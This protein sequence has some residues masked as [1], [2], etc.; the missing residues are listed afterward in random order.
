MRAACCRSTRPARLCLRPLTAFQSIIRSGGYLRADAR[1][2]PLSQLQHIIIYSSPPAALPRTAPSRC[3]LALLGAA[4]AA[5]RLLT[6]RP[7]PLFSSVPA[8]RTAPPR[9][10]CSLVLLAPPRGV[11]A[12]LALRALL[13]SVQAP[14]MLATGHAAAARSR[15]APAGLPAVAL[16]PRAVAAAP[17]TLPPRSVAPLPHV[18]PCSQLSRVRAPR[19]SRFRSRP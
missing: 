5:G 15:Q 3:S 18:A 4:L 8:P 12:P 2:P 9:S 11:S 19:R 7:S 17:L 1:P 10:P 13:R 14:A 6:L 16:P